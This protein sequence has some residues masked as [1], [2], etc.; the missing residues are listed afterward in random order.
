MKAILST[1]TGLII[2]VIL[3]GV[4]IGYIF[5][6]RLPDTIASHLSHS[7]RVP[8]SI[9]ALNAHWNEIDILN[10]QVSNPPK[11]VLNRA[12]SC[13]TLK[14]QAP[15]T[16][17][18]KNRVIIDEISLDAVYLSLEFNSATTTSGNWT[19]LMSNLQSSTTS[20]P[21][22]SSNRS[23]LI[24]KLVITNLDVD[25]VYRKEGSKVRHL[26]RI[27]RL[28]LVNISSEGGMPMDQLM[29]SVL[30]EMLKEVFI[31]QNLNN[32]LQEL[33]KPDGLLKDYIKPFKLF[34]VP[35]QSSSEVA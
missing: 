27:P 17:Y 28:E 10:I 32:M 19:T 14:V 6:F 26:P 8:V 21:S 11:S 9:E 4:V 34:F 1:L 20:T 15:F 31:K 2:L 35:I 13:Q 18:I 5:W 33:I 25:V 12:F 16:N 7:M 23:L 3:V 29:H 22:T 30:G 24:R